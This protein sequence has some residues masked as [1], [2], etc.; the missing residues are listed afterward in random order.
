MRNTRLL[1]VDGTY[2]YKYRTRYIFRDYTSGLI[3]YAAL[4]RDDKE[5]VRPLFERVIEMYGKPTGVISDMQPAFIE[6]VNKLW[7]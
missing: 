3:L 2:S 5:S 6:L 4:A 7:R 1:S